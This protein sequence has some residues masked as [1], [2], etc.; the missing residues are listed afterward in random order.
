MKITDQI[1]ADVKKLL[2]NGVSID[3]ISNLSGVSIRTIYRIKQSDSF[4]NNKKIAC[5]LTED[6]N[7]KQN[8]FNKIIRKFR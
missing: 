4:N 2:N 6:T 3:E 7:I 1:Y 8:W 5:N